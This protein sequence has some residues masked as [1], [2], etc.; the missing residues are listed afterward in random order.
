MNPLNLYSAAMMIVIAL[1]LAGYYLLRHGLSQ[2]RLLILV[3]MAFVLVAVWYLVRPRQT[4]KTE[5]AD[6]RNQIG[7]GSPVLLEFQSPY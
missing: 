5:L 6:I 3:V 1:L 4:R 2:E 7:A